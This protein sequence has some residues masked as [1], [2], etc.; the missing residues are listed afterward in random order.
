MAFRI[1][2]TKHE[3]RVR[4]QAEYIASHEAEQNKFWR[5]RIKS[6]QH[7]QAELA[8]N[9]NQIG[10]EVA[11]TVGARNLALSKQQDRPLTFIDFLEGINNKR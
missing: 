9:D 4:E 3:R 1:F 10:R 11:L 7:A 2:E 5:E 8:S 6:A